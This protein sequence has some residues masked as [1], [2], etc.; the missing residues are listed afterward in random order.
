MGR[1]S[2]SQDCPSCKATSDC[3]KALRVVRRGPSRPSSNLGPTA[4]EPLNPSKS[5]GLV[6]R[7]GLGPLHRSDQAGSCLIFKCSECGVFGCQLAFDRGAREVGLPCSASPRGPLHPAPQFRGETHSDAI[8]LHLSE[9]SLDLSDTQ[10]RRLARSLS[11]LG[12]IAVG[13]TFR[14]RFYCANG[15]MSGS[16]GPLHGRKPTGGRP[17]LAAAAS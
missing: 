1:W 12:Q 15:A 14:T 8:T 5:R 17:V 2:R 9:I 3:G 6:L 10:P 11:D 4:Q 7:S 16:G 13:Q